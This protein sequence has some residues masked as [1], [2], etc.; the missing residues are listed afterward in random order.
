MLFV[1][2]ST[3]FNFFV[4]VCVC[5]C[6]RACVLILIICISSV[7]LF[8]FNS[9]YLFNLVVLDIRKRDREIKKDNDC[10]SIL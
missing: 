2:I 3:H 5:V 1:L 4:C 8:Y 6:M 9:S 10:L 7:D